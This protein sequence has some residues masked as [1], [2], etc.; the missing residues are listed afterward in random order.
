MKNHIKKCNNCKNFDAYF[1]KGARDLIKQNAGGVSLIK[2]TR[3]LTVGVRNMKKK[4][5]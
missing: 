1:I 2:K 4:D 5:P 3:T